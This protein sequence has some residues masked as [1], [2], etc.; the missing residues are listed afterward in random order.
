MWMMELRWEFTKEKI[1]REKE[2]K[3]AFEQEKKVR[4]KKK[5]R[6]YVFDKEQRNEE[7]KILTKKKRKKT[8]S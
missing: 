4:F 6:K 5:E 3:H 2:R 7:N 8:R 1:L